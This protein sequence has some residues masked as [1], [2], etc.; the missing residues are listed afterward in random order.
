MLGD[1]TT[2]WSSTRAATA[3][4]CRATKDSDTVE[5]RWYVSYEEHDQEELWLSD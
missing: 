1:A 5:R 4:L 3:T 2:E